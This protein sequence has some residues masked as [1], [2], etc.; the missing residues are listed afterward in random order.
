METATASPHWPSTSWQPPAAM[1]E[2]RVDFGRQ[3]PGTGEPG[4]PPVVFWLMRRNC[5]VTP[6]QVGLVYLG[7]CGVT[8]LIAGFFLSMGAPW[9]LAFAGLELLAL[10]VAFLV[11]AR[12]VAD[13]ELLRLVGSSLQFERHVGPS[14][15]RAELA[16]DRVTVEPASGQGSLVKLTAHGRSVLVGRF[17]RP[18]LR[19]AF[20]KELRLT[21][22]HNLAAGGLRS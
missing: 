10:G 3:E 11:F 14:V 12:H 20:A 18:E 16:A 1:G 17:L 2:P 22:R 6:R 7:I 4:K 9:V 19:A 13:R 21:L 8:L 5:S 15:V